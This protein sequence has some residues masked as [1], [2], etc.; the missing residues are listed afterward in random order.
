MVLVASA[1][2]DILDH[3]KTFYQ[4]TSEC[5]MF[6]VHAHPQVSSGARC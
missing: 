1:V 5:F 4:M 6:C 2:R 3:L